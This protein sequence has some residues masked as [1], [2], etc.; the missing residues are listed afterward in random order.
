LIRERRS[1]QNL[2][3][4]KLNYV[5]PEGYLRY[6][7]EHFAERRNG[8]TRNPDRRRKADPSGIVLIDP[9]LFGTVSFWGTDHGTR[10][11]YI[12]LPVVAHV[13]IYSRAQ[14]KAANRPRVHR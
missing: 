5:E 1:C 14:I 2:G 12:L 8:A 4:G 3:T 7:L 6:V 11:I 10:P 13:H 9:W